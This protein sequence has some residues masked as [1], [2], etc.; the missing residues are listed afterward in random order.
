MQVLELG[1]NEEYSNITEVAQML[2]MALVARN[3]H[4][5]LKHHSSHKLIDT[6]QGPLLLPRAQTWIDV[7]WRIRVSAQLVQV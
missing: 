4:P 7:V 3:F 6:Y 5:I 1:E 2:G